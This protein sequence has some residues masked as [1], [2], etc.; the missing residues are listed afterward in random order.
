MDA[1]LNYSADLPEPIAGRLCNSDAGIEVNV[2]NRVQQR[3]ALFHRALERFASADQPHAA[4]AF[5]DDGRDD[6]V[7][8]IGYAVRFAAGVD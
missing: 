7:F 5:V 6:G 8:Q 2:L 3:D 1:G 4:G